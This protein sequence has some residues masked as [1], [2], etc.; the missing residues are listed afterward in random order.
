MNEMKLLL[1]REH[2]LEAKDQRKSAMITSAFALLLLLASLFWT[3]MAGVIP[4]VGQPSWK[5][6]GMI[7]DF[8]NLTEGSSNVDNFQPPS[9]TPADRP[10]VDQ[11]NPSVKS[12]PTPSPK[13]VESSTQSNQTVAP[14]N[15]NTQTTN[16][17]STTQTNNTATNNSTKSQNGG[18]NDGQG[19]TPGNFGNPNSKT[20]D[21]NGMF[22][23]GPGIGGTAGRKPVKLDLPK[24]NVQQEA[25]IKF[26]FII[27]PDG[28]VAFVKS[29]ATPYP[30][31]ARV[32]KEAI[33]R[34]RFSE[35]DENEG[36]LKTS[37]VITF[38]LQ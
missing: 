13:V 17:N 23:F 21:G 20:L 9:P 8:G 4:P 6:I 37:V 31:L 34:W 5:T 22:D 27:L 16:N 38:R 11:S 14:S 19:K 32:G 35:V 2:K 1:E 12:N 33:E 36:N 18:S 28:K 26:N 7:S 25:K 10:K 3:A 30:D 15:T 29:E 24:Y